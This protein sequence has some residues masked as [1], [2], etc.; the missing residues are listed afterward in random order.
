M[1]ALSAGL[2]LLVQAGRMI[3]GL[4]DLCNFTMDVLELGGDFLDYVLQLPAEDVL[5]LLCRFVHFLTF[6][7]RCQILSCLLRRG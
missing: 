7:Q 4:H 3:P 6:R 5:Q 1:R 2:R